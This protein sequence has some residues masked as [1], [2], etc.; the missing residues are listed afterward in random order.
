MTQFNNNFSNDGNGFI[1]EENENKNNIMPHQEERVLSHLTIKQIC[2]GKNVDDDDNVLVI[3]NKVINQLMIMGTVMKIKH[4]QS[5]TVLLI[6]DCTGRISVKF[7]NSDDN[8]MIKEKMD[9]LKFCLF[10]F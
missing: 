6:N 5:H 3:D 4:Q 10:V 9:K 8:L 2:R 1:A 7:W